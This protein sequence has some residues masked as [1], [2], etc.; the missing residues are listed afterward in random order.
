MSIHV[1]MASVKAVLLVLASGLC[2]ALPAAAKPQNPLPDREENTTAIQT[3]T[4]KPEEI[5]GFENQPAAIQEMLK[6]A[7]LL[8][9]Q[10]LSY[11]PGSSDPASGGTDCSGFIYHLL[12]QPTIE[13]HDWPWMMEG[14]WLWFDY[15]TLYWLWRGQL[16]QVDLADYLS[17]I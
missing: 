15:S 8:T 1:R 2:S 16:G 7:L 5:A 10:H 11:K 3:A 14:A 4:L 6:Y 12:Q 13:E 17:L 9:S